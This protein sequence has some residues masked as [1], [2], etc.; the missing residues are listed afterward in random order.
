MCHFRNNSVVR[1]SLVSDD[2]SKAEKFADVLE[3]K[4]QIFPAP[5]S[6]HTSEAPSAAYYSSPELHVRKVQKY[7]HFAELVL[8][9]LHL[10]EATMLTVENIQEPDDTTL[11][12]YTVR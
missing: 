5:A 3:L 2:R 4:H 1:L 7:P 10:A 9:K 6:E 8:N 12:T 11:T